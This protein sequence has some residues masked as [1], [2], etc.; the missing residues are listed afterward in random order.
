[1]KAQLLAVLLVVGSVQAKSVPHTIQQQLARVTPKDLLGLRSM[2]ERMTQHPTSRAEFIK[3]L[4]QKA[5][6]VKTQL[7]IRLTVLFLGTEVYKVGR[8]L[9][10][11]GRKKL[12]SDA[13]R[14][15]RTA[16][17]EAMAAVNEAAALFK[18]QDVG[19]KKNL[20]SVFPFIPQLIQSS[21]RS[22]QYVAKNI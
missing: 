8:D 18:K 2:A 11:Q 1:M 6:N 22:V 21:Q 3:E 12:S 10:T 20:Q 13:I 14:F 17:K 19:T 15:L 4:N 9:A 5:P 7:A 16:S